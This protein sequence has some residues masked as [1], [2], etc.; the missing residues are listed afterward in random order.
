[1]K[2]RAGIDPDKPLNLHDRNLLSKLIAAMSR[3][4]TGGRGASFEAVIKILNNTG[5]SAITSAKTLSH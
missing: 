4:E 5:G 1:M 2:A 3:Y